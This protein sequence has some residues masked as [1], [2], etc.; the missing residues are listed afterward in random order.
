LLFK[1]FNFINFLN[2]NF[3]IIMMKSKIIIIFIAMLFVIPTLCADDDKNEIYFED[4][5]I[6][7]IG[8]CCTIV[9]GGDDPWTGGLVIGHL[10]YAGIDIDDTPVRGYTS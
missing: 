7:V 1:F 6:L 3:I 9:S 8:R 5:K 10:K 2:Y 4:A